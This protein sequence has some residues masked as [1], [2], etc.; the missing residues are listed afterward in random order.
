MFGKRDMS[1]L[2]SNFPTLDLFGSFQNPEE[3]FNL[4][5]T[6]LFRMIKYFDYKFNEYIKYSFLVIEKYFPTDTTFQE[7]NLDTGHH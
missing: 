5:T 7:S 3:F 2:M 6:A 1:P 4:W